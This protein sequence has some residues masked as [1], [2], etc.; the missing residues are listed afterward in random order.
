MLVNGLTHILTFN[1]RHFARFPGI[2]VL[3]PASVA[4][5]GP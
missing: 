4:A 1:A 5:A 3:D 2:A